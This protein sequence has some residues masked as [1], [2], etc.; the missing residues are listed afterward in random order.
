MAKD[1]ALESSSLKIMISTE[2]LLEKESRKAQE[3]NIIPQKEKSLK[4]TSQII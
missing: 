2:E 3:L 1:M 4:E